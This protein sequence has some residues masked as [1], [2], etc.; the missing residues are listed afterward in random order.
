MGR[1]ISY[2]MQMMFV[3]SVG[4]FEEAMNTGSGISRLDFIQGYDFSFNIDR[5]ALK[6]IGS[7]SFAT[8]QT[9]F[10]PDVNFNIQYLLNDGWNEKYI[11]LDMPQG[12][13]SNPF[14]T[15]LSSTGDRN[16]Y[17]SVAKNDG[18]DQNLQSEIVNSNILSIG[19]AYISSY[20]ISVAVNQLATVSCSFIGSNASVQ[21]YETSK[22][23]PSVN[24]AVTGQNAEDADKKFALKF[25]D[26]NRNQAYIPKATETF[27]G[28]CPY[29]KCKITPDFQSDGVKSPITFGFFDAVANN[30]QSMQFAV[31]FERKSLYGFGNNHPYGR[32]VQR[33]IV[34]TLALSALI[35]DFQAENLS[36]VFHNEGWSK[37][38]ILI[39]FFNLSDVKKFTISLN[40]LTLE[41]YSLGARIG[42]RVLVDTNWTVEVNNGGGSNVEMGGSYRNGTLDTTLVNESFSAPQFFSEIDTNEYTSFGVT[43]DGYLF[44]WGP[45]YT[46][47]NFTT[48]PVNIFNRSDVKTVNTYGVPIELSASF[49]DKSGKAW[50]WGKNINGQLGDG[51]VIE[52]STPVAV[53]GNKTFCKIYINSQNSLAVDKNG[54]GWAWGYTPFVG[55]NVVTPGNTCSPVQVLNYFPPYI[56]Y[57]VRFCKVS[58]GRNFIVNIDQNGKAWAWGNYNS[59]YGTLGD[60]T[61]NNWVAMVPVYGNKTF[62][63]VSSG[64]YSTI[65]LDKNGKAWGW[66]QNNYS[67]LGN[68]NPANAVRSPVAV[69]G[70]KTF[71]QVSCG[72]WFSLA[73]DK[74]GKA[75][76][77][78]YNQSGELGAGFISTAEYTP[79]SVVG[80]KTFCQISAG[81]RYALAI[82]KNGKTW[83]WGDQ[84]YGRLGNILSQDCKT[85][86][87]LSGL[88]KTFCDISG[89][90]A[91]DKN[92][93]AWA[94]GQN[95]Y[96]EVGDNSTLWKN[97]PVSVYGN[98][99]FCKISYSNARSFAI[100]K[101]GKA[102]GWGS[103]ML[104]DNSLDDRSTPVAVYGDK[105]FCQISASFTHTLAIDKNGR[106]WAW[107]SAGDGQLGIGSINGINT[108][109]PI[110]VFGNK[111]F[112]K[113]FAS[114]YHSLA[115]DKNGKGW[116]W[117]YSYDGRGG[118]GYGLEY[119]PVA[120]IGNK[121]FCEISSAGSEGIA[122]DKNGKL[123]TWGSLALNIGTDENGEMIEQATSPMAVCTNKTFCK[124]SADTF[125]RR[126]F[127]IDK[128]YKAWAWGYP[129]SPYYALGTINAYPTF[130]PAAIYGNKKFLKV[131]PFFSIPVNEQGNGYS[132]I[133]LD[134]NGK[135]WTWGSSLNGNLG[136]NTPK[137]FSPMRVYGF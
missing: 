107:G 123:W 61:I 60:G 21:D 124:I 1:P 27:A 53:L 42:D 9:Q 67:Q 114:N 57:T 51:T 41:S 74:N 79:V 136:Q 92:G 20:E 87:D 101:N 2:E 90:L 113:I 69:C 89:T 4:A 117:G 83:A 70:N 56:P 68:N 25:L 50:A 77:W 37:S 118:Y 71:C 94:W 66:G 126:Y 15:I 133:G 46:W 110:S 49:I 58:L 73:I 137:P 8:R 106:A 112:C 32:K 47:Q 23:L 6:Q 108:K 28:G 111:T 130:T 93:K 38:S 31:Q 80:N 122:I 34:A 103:G 18:K 81:L 91:I 35:D 22:Y 104:G 76:G 82:D 119:T 62:C 100:D 59:I 45:K 125:S 14:D 48:T 43:K 88:N 63:Q 98:K 121:T 85:P 11:G 33:P 17:V 10:A 86:K 5:P 52:R 12:S 64:A 132:V 39:E 134:D 109:T 135:V 72:F 30:F 120:I 102:W 65:A 3:G 26:N 55:I 78:G 7:D 40:N 13:L 131:I 84:E 99:T 19:N 44:S 24:S 115:I 29:S 54:T 75:W 96:G 127:A 128:D 105:T 16:F 95:R 36:K 129:S 97:T 116:G